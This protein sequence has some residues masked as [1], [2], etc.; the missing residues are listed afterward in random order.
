M[1]RK[2]KRRI[3]SLS[4][5][6]N[7]FYR[8]ISTTKPSALILSVIASVIAVFLF[9]GGLYD[10]IT[11]P[12]PTGGYHKQTGFMIIFPRLSD[13]FIGESLVVMVLYSLGI[14]GLIAMYQSTRY[15]SKPRQAYIMFLVSIVLLIIVYASLEILLRMKG[16][17]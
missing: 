3:S 15:A 9:G 12:Y 1:S 7:R 13:Q 2:A 10:I 6:I 5:S 4:Y 14:I 8:K 16:V 11:S 17:R